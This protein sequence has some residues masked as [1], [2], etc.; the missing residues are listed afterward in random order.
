MESFSGW[1]KS[2]KLLCFESIP[3]EA[4]DESPVSETGFKK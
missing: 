2:K 4:D 1:L 3:C